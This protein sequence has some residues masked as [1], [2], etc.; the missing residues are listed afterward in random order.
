VTATLLVG[1][2]LVASGGVLVAFRPLLAVSLVT[3]IAGAC[4]LAA[5]GVAVL[6][7]GRELGSEFHSV[8]DPA[9]GIDGLSAFFLVVVAATAVPALLFARDALP[10]TRSAVRRG[11]PRR[12]PRPRGPARRVRLSRDHAPR[13]GRVWVRCSRSRTRRRSA[14]C[15]ERVLRGSC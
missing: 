11:D 2:A 8:V 10:G 4:T 3:Q 7:S 15:W 14:P 9:F 6:A 1:A 12:S 5:A 13:R